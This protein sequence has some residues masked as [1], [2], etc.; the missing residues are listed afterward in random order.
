MQTVGDM[1]EPKHII[2]ILSIDGGGVRGIIPATIL[3]SLERELQELD[4]THKRIADY[5][6]VIAGTSTGG[7]ITAM[8]AVPD[9]G[10]Q[11]RPLFTAEEIKRFYFDKC[12]LIFPPPPGGFWG[13]F[14]EKL[15]KMKIGSGHVMGPKY[16]GDP[17]HQIISQI[18]GNKKLSDTL[19]NV[20][21]PAYDIQLQ[22]PVIFSNF[23]G[24]NDDA[25]LSD[26]CIGTSATPTYLP[27]HHFHTHNNFDLI[28]GGVAANNPM[29][30][31][32]NHLT[33]Q[34]LTGGIPNRGSTQ[35]WPLNEALK[36]L[37]SK[38]DI[39]KKC[40][41]LSLGTGQT[42]PGYQATDA[43]HNGLWGSLS[44]DGKSPLIDMQKSP[45]IDIFMQSSSA[46]VDIQTSIMFQGLQLA[47]NYLRI[48]EPNLEDKRSA[49]DLST[50][51]NLN[52]LKDI[53][54]QLLDKPVSRVN[55]HTGWYE[56]VD[57]KGT[58]REELKRLAK[59]L[60]DERKKR[61]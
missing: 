49:L 1:A 33:N 40:V 8:L 29:L 61:M 43:A 15:Q 16:S 20:V 39:L 56:P 26:V 10:K 21:I 35:Y 6:D 18:M 14:L 42:K 17:L 52:A 7:L 53:G 34:A 36:A 12:P 37:N 57:G 55:L 32:I 28:D 45:L 38:E 50:A 2:T 44:K 41:V 51:E 58:N 22:C 31:S 3:E 59:K 11:P 54:I 30:L 9:D 19:A 27:P 23:E 47:D 5:F 25:K 46:M 4:G 60:S 13:W 24:N 48:Q